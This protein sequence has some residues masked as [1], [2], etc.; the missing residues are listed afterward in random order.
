MQSSGASCSLT[1]YTV[2]GQCPTV[3]QSKQPIG[4]KDFS[5]PIDSTVELDDNVIIHHP[6]LVNLYGC[7]IGAET[8]IGAFVEIQ[9]GVVVGRRCK[10]SSHTFLCEGVLI[11]DEVF[12]GHGVMFTNDIYPRATNAQGRPKDETQMATWQNLRWP[13]SLDRIERDY[14][15]RGNDW[16]QSACCRRRCG[17]AERACRRNRCGGPGKSNWFRRWARRIT[18]RCYEYAAHQ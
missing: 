7:R 1:S 18:P 3:W 5:M 17:D 8:R 10:I 13:R 16:D 6:E 14:S 12:I 2:C 11:E 15:A 9:K 4:I